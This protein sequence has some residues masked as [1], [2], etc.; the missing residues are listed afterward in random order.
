MNRDM[1][2]GGWGYIEVDSL[3]GLRGVLVGDN[4]LVIR[5]I[6]M[7]LV[8]ELIVYG[9]CNKVLVGGRGYRGDEVIIKSGWIGTIEFN[10]C[11]D[12]RV[13]NLSIIS[14]RAYVRR[15]MGM[16]EDEYYE[17]DGITIKNGSI[18]VRV[19]GCDISDC[20]DGLIDI[21]RGCD[22]VNISWC[23]FYYSEVT[24]HRFCNLVGHS[25]DNR[26][27]DGG[28]LNIVF[29]HNWW[30]ELCDMR[31]PRVRYGRVHV[32]NNY[33]SCI[34]NNRCIEARIGSEV[35]IENNYFDGVNNPWVVGEDGKVGERGNV[36]GNGSKWSEGNMV[37]RNDI[38]SIF[39]PSY[40]YILDTAEETKRLVMKYAG[41]NI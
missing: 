31:M 29:H 10:G 18:G 12:I 39:R 9:V 34:G 6:G 21:T 11:R 30:G 13:E 36:L 8:G 5:V 25:D 40:K 15:E 32:Y 20:S 7:I 27:E 3:E 35:L 16:R 23:K 28:K 1:S 2:D 19:R 4:K 17:G 38:D 37:P 22:D 26:E 14:P 41:N 33:Y 24:P